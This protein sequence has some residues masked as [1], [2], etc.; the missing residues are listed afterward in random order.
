MGRYLFVFTVIFVYII[1]VTACSTQPEKIVETVI[2]EVTSTPVP[3]DTPLPEPTE[4]PEI[5]MDS[6]REYSETVFEDMYGSC[7]GLSRKDW[8]TTDF[9]LSLLFR[10]EAEKCIK[11]ISTHE[12]PINCENDTECNQLSELAKEYTTLVTDGW[13]LF[14]KGEDTLNEDLVSEGLGMFWDADEMWL[15]IRDVVFDLEDKYGWD[16]HQ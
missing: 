12:I 6:F 15:E 7:V 8:A 13:R 5:S 3:T 4:A 9:T 16:I 10:A 1:L 11:L 2:V 14:R